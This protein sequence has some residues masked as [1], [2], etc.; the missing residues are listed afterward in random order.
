[1]VNCYD[2]ENVYV[3]A[4]GKYR[5][6]HTQEESKNRLFSTSTHTQKLHARRWGAK[7][8]SQTTIE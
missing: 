6:L 8:L 7:N 1:M 3:I 4:T 2:F 5:F